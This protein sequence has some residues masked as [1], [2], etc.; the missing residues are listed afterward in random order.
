ME[1]NVGSGKIG[2]GVDEPFSEVPTSKEYHA[3]KRSCAAYKGHLTRICQEIEPL[4]VNS[5]NLKIVELRFLVLSRPSIDLTGTYR[6][7]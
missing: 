2:R 5:G 4:L 7:C 3:L 1:A 6:V